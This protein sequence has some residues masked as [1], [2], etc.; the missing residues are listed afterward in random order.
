MPS[1]D[2][3]CP[4]CGF[5]EEYI[6]SIKASPEYLC[7]KCNTVMGRLI[8]RNTT[9][10]IFKGGT[11]TMSWKEKRIRM[12]RS[13]DLG[14]KQIDRYGGGPKLRPNVA[15][16]ETETW[17]DAAKLAKE[18]GMDS[19]TYDAHIEKEKNVSKVSGVDDSKWKKAKDNK[20]K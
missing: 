7:P 8:S 11:E 5:Q 17:S 3:K 10:F 6:H 18:A 9:G 1:Y 12:K 13:N 16:H 2:Y 14:V 15:G 19:S 4:S 20:N